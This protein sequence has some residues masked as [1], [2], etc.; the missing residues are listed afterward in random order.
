MK[1]LLILFILVISINIFSITSIN[2]LL[3]IEEGNLK[4]EFVDKAK[5]SMSYGVLNFVE[6][7]GGIEED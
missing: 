5:F 4:F 6:I 2:P 3:F 1:K 7:G